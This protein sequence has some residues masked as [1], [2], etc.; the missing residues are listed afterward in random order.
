MLYRKNLHTQL[1]AA[2]FLERDN[3]LSITTPRFMRR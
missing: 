2:M 1:I 3:L